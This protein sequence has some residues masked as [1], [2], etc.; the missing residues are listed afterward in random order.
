MTDILNELPRQLF[1]GLSEAGLGTRALELYDESVGL[2]NT[3]HLRGVDERIRN[4]E[5]NDDEVEG[6]VLFPMIPGYEG[7][8]FRAAILAHA[9]R[10]RGYRPTVLRCASD[11]G[12]C[13]LGTCLYRSFD[14]DES[15]VCDFCQRLS[16]AT[17]EAFGLDTIDTGEVL[18]ASYEPPSKPDDIRSVT[19]RGVP[20]SEFALATTRKFY[21]RYSID[22]TASPDRERYLA[23]LRDAM[24]LVDVYE[25]LFER[26]DFSA[27]VVNESVYVHGGVP[28][29]VARRHDVPGYVQEVGFQAGSLM[30]GRAQNRSP[31]PH[32]V[33][34]GA[35]EQFLARELGDERRERIAAVMDQ[36]KTGDGSMNFSATSDVSVDVDDDTVVGLFTNLLW[37]ASMELGDADLPF[38]NTYDWLETTIATLQSAD[39]VQLVLKTHPSESQ[40]DTNE[41]VAEWVERTYDGT[42]PNVELLPP[43]TDVDTYE[44]MAEVDL[45]LVFTSTTG[46]EMAYDG[47][48]VVVADRAPYRGFGFTFDPTTK[49]EYEQLLAERDELSMTDEMR[50]RAR[51]YAY[52]SFVHQNFEFP[53][54]GVWGSQEIADFSVSHDQL[55]PGNENFD[56]IVERVTSGDPALPALPR[57]PEQS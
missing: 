51:R 15:Y 29:A 25:T 44:L 50:A 11:G 33:D 55:K 21:R 36:R 12:T 16:A 14:W 3:D 39:D 48:P 45:G 47:T 52:L 7:V 27:V 34:S 2:S 10:T 31:M 6:S 37:D 9:F 49:D 32:F 24:K 19:Y 42:P 1:R 43:D 38:E 56:A 5:L 23:F 18:P 20:V 28:L 41:S 13:D 57:A 26:R 46:L 22:L 54:V 35:T 40:R 4:Y 53:F 17:T 8:T 30:F